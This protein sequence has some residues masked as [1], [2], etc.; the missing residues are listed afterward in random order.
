MDRQIEIESDSRENAWEINYCSPENYKLKSNKY[1]SSTLIWR[2]RSD[3]TQTEV[4]I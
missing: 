2:I 3:Q 1:I 4:Y